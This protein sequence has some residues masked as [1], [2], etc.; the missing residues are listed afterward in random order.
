MACR[1][2]RLRLPAG[3]AAFVMCLSLSTAGGSA[4]TPAPA[5]EQ[6]VVYGMFGGLALLLDV[7]R[8]EKP[9]GLGIVAIVGTAMHTGTVYAGPPMKEEPYQLGV[10]VKPLVAA[11]YTVFSINYRGTPAFRYP[12]GVRDAERAVRFVRHHAA[13]FGI[14]RERIGAVGAS[15]GGYL[16]SMLAVGAAPGDTADPDAVNR[17]EAD[18]QAVVAFCPPTDLLGSFNEWGMTAMAAYVGAARMPDPSPEWQLYKQASPISSVT[19]DD[20]PVLFIHGDKDPV[21]PPA[22][23][24]KMEAALKA[25]GVATKLVRVPGAGHSM[26]P[27]PENVDFTSEMIRWFDSHLRSR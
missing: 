9:N 7:H 19:A 3:I 26:R 17:E 1:P 22:H 11:G 16:A 25:A 6:N 18:V 15:S 2:S 13:R 23:S 5:V 14:D 4:Q 12:A 20:A 21:V 24:E 27:N 10:F 8:P